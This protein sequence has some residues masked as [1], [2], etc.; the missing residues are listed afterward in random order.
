MLLGRRRI[1]QPSR[2][3]ELESIGRRPHGRSRSPISLP[4]HQRHRQQ[5]PTRDAD[6]CSSERRSVARED[7]GVYRV[8]VPAVSGGLDRTGVSNRAV[9]R[10][11]TCRRC[12]ICRR[13]RFGGEL[14]RVD[15]VRYSVGGAASPDWRAS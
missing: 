15:V 12:A 7:D 5:H 14:I 6:Q 13:C 2:P 3:F 9:R 8:M 4:A 11:A 10:H 1:P